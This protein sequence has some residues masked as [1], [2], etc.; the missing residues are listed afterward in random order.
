[1]CTETRFGVVRLGA[2][3]AAALIR[4]LFKQK[5]RSPA[6]VRG[7]LEYGSV[8]LDTGYFPAH[9]DLVWDPHRASPYLDLVPMET[10]P[11][12]ATQ[13]VFVIVLQ[14]TSTKSRQ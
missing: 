8:M 2:G 11:A 14:Q 13:H 9:S 5:P 7:F 1:M 12:L 10:R 3:S 6:R 4:I